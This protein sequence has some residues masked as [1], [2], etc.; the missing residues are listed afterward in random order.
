MAW[1]VGSCS[2][3]H[4]EADGLKMPALCAAISSMDGPMSSVWSSE[5]DAMAVT[6]GFG[7]IFCGVVRSTHVALQYGHVDPFDDERV[8]G[9]QKQQLKIARHVDGLG[10]RSRK[11]GPDFEEALGKYVFADGTSSH[12]DP[13][14][15]VHDVG[16]RIH[17]D[18][19][20]C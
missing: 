18:F 5:T 13:L 19:A 12:Q 15:H 6:T 17:P 11:F 20:R 2:A 7:M 1:T 4:A 10:G 14:P 8:Y 9:E 16:R 3:D